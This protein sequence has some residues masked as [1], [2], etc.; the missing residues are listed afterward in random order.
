[1]AGTATE[2]A[3]TVTRMVAAAEVRGGSAR[4]YHAADP[5]V[6]SQ[7][8]AQSFVAA[9]NKGDSMKA[10]LAIRLEEQVA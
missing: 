7:H 9:P 6:S 3:D 4:V 5:I 1:M 8:Y 10:P 2:A